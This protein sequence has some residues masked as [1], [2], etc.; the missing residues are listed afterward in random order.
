MSIKIRDDEMK[1]YNNSTNLDKR[2]W[3]IYERRSTIN[4]IKE[5]KYF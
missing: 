3:A 1:E 2:R 4:K 5:Q